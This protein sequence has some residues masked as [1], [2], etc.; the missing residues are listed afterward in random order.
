[1]ICRVFL[2]IASCL[3]L[4][5][6]GT[7]LAQ[8]GP[9][10]QQA[11]CG[12]RDVVIVYSDAAELV[13][14]CSALSELTAYFRAIGFEIT[15]LGSLEFANRAANGSAS[16]GYFDRA[17]ARVVVYRSAAVAPWGLSWNLTLAA[18]FLRHELIHMMVWR[19]A[20]DPGRLPR[21]WHEFIAYAIQLDLMETN[22]LKEVLARRADVQP[23]DGLL[24]VNE[25][26]YG[27]DPEAFAIS[28]YKTYRTRGDA[29]LVQQLLAGKIIPA[30]SLPP[31]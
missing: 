18:S 26:T 21:E 19:A 7:A 6:A 15:P 1:M 23:F 13:A 31:H 30:V 2:L 20:K 12:Y 4:A 28:A 27:M 24:A 17:R 9:D 25:F 8:P 5:I 22:V 16:H 29:Q 10:D 3:A 14:A 11:D